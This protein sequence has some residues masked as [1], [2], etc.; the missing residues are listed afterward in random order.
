[1]SI[2]HRN[3]THVPGEAV[4]RAEEANSFFPGRKRL[5]T[6]CGRRAVR[7]GERPTSTRGRRRGPFPPRDGSRLRRWCPPTL[8]SFAV[9]PERFTRNARKQ[10]GD[11]TLTRHHRLRDQDPPEAPAWRPPRQPP[12]D[13]CIASIRSR[14]P[15]RSVA[16]ED[17]DRSRSDEFGFGERAQCRDRCPAFDRHD[18]QTV[19]WTIFIVSVR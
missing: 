4:T 8:G 1:M 12:A 18:Q 13:P 2:I 6:R 15:R 19:G 9:G 16:E 10:H 14:Q 17:P 5:P 11:E 3:W 7:T